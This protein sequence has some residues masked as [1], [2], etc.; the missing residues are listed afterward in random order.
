[1]FVTLVFEKNANFFRRKL[2]NIVII[3]FTPGPPH[4]SGS[5][6][7]RANFSCVGSLVSTRHVVTTKSCFNVGGLIGNCKSAAYSPC[8]YLTVSLAMHDMYSRNGIL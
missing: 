3:T 6:W 2:A 7:Q 1:L 8:Q 4:D 5:G